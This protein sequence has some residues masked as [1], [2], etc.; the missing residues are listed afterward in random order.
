MT[1]SQSYKGASS[2]PVDP[3]MKISSIRISVGKCASVTGTPITFGMFYNS[4]ES[5]IFVSLHRG[6]AS[7]RSQGEKQSHNLPCSQWDSTLRSD[8]WFLGVLCCLSKKEM[9]GQLRLLKGLI[10]MTTCFQFLSVSTILLLIFFFFASTHVSCLVKQLPLEVPCCMFISLC[11]DSP[12][13]LKQLKL[14]HCQTSKLNLYWRYTPCSS[15]LEQLTVSW[16]TF[17]VFSVC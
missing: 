15:H 9:E 3:Q 8:F 16:Q 4:R 14:S 1:L 11:K 12:L 5:G 6:T 2:F 10:V 7:F 17:V 13:D